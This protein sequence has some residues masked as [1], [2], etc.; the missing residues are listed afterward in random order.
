MTP[1][2]SYL[3]TIVRRRWVVSMIERDSSAAVSPPNR[4]HEVIVWR[5]DDATNTRGEMIAMGS[6][7]AY[8]TWACRLLMAENEAAV[9]EGENP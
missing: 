1:D 4:Y 5:Y 2:E 8:Y 7:F 9:I 3:W 6:G